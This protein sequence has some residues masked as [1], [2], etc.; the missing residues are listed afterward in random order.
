MAFVAGIALLVIYLRVSRAPAEPSHRAPM[1]GAV[2]CPRCGAGNTPA[3]TVCGRC[4]APLTAVLPC[5]A[6]PPP[7]APPRLPSIP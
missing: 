5:P 7:A 4:G 6:M 1:A 3:T 2:I